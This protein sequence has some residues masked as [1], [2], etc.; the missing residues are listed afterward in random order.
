M[1][2]YSALMVKPCRNDSV[3]RVWKTISERPSRSCL[4]AYT[5]C[6]VAEL[7]TDDD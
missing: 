7:A 1:Q 5:V 4:T 6:P 3:H 2:G